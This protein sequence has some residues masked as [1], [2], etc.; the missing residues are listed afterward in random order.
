MNVARTYHSTALLLKDG[1]VLSA[2]GGACGDGCAANHL[3]GQIFSP[4]YLFA[5]ERQPRAAVRRST[6]APALGEAGADDHRAG[7]RADREVQHG[8]PLGDHA[9]D[10]HRPALPADPVHRSRRRLV[11]ALSSSR[12]RT[13]SCRATTGSSRSTARACRRSAA[14]SRCCATTAARARASTSRARARCLPARSR[15]RNDAAARNGRY[16][17]VPSRAGRDRRAD[18]PRTAPC[19]RSRCPSPASTGSRPRVL[20]P[21]ASQNS[22]WVHGRRRAV[23]SGFLLGDAGQQRVSDRLREPPGR[24][25]PGARHARRRRSH[26]RSD[27]PRGRHAPRLDAARLRRPSGRTGRHRRRRSTRRAGRLPERSDRVGGQRRRRGT[28]T[29]ATRSR[30]IRPRR[31]PSTASRPLGELPHSS[32]TL[33]VETSSGADRIWN[34]NPDN[35]SVTVTECG[36]HRAR[37]DR[38]GRAAVVAREGA[39]RERGVRREQGLRDDLSVIDTQTLAVARTISLPVA[40]QPH[41]LVFAPASDALYVVLEGLARV[42]QR[43]AATGALVAARRS[44]DGRATSRSAATAASSTSPTS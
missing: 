14:P 11:R 16:I 31:C 30:T 12:T 35:R 24:R 13:C 40:S 6:A 28:A 18:Q 32:S 36:G 17:S 2:G 44:P 34:V 22:F 23:A 43:S 42:E 37:R 19:S 8:A 41:G 38:R 4:P 27:P 10:Q 39:A 5:V 15:S 26:G 21:S 33:I 25:R 7:H 29:T 9:R 1:R 20:A 3:D